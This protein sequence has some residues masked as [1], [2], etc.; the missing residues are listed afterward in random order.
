MMT[1]AVYLTFNINRY[2]YVSIYNA[3]MKLIKRYVLVFLVQI[4]TWP[5]HVQKSECFSNT[6][7]LEELSIFT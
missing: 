2:N 7:N 3:V 1:G 6:H 4:N 5:I